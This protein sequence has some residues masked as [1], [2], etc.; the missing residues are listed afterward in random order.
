MRWCW[1]LLVAC[2]ASRADDPL[3]GKWGGGSGGRTYELRAD[4]SLVGPLAGAAEGCDRDT[5]AIAACAAQQTWEHDGSKVTFHRG[6]LRAPQR[7]LDGM[8]AAKHDD[9]C[10]CK[11]ESID[12]E[13]K[14]GALV[15]GKERAVRVP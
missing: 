4:G 3:V 12:L 11:L 13:Y 15:V 2:S 8:F 14:D 9:K 1:L 10:T 7:G 6:G 5:A